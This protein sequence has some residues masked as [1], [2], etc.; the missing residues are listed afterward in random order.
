MGPFGFAISP[1]YLCYVYS[2]I[3]E[4]EAWFF[5]QAVDPPDGRSGLGDFSMVVN[6][7]D[8]E[9][10]INCKH[11]AVAIFAAICTVSSAARRHS[12]SSPVALPRQ[13]V[14]SAFTSRY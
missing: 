10:E 7:Y 3:K 11:V 4:S 8:E 1:Y 13:K 5:K 12:T 6:Y 14:S 9:W 2:F